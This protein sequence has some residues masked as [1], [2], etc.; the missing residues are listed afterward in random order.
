MNNKTYGNVASYPKRL[1]RS[2]LERVVLFSILTSIGGVASFIFVLRNSEYD[3]LF[4][5]LGLTASFFCFMQIVSAKIKVSTALAGIKAE[6]LVFNVVNKGVKC[7]IIKGGILDKKKG[8]IDL[9]VVGDFIA[10]IETKNGKG[11][12]S[13]SREGRLALNGKEMHR[14]PLVQSRKAAQSV[15]KVLGKN[16]SPILCITNLENS[17]SK[18]EGVNIVSANDLPM[19]LNSLPKILNSEERDFVTEKLLTN[20]KFD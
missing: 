8:D 2:S 12:V 13:H 11:V 1:L 10:V 9:I 20:L 16:V 4:S 5:L 15:S 19:F 3:R 6:N 14:M 17:P 7:N 18:I